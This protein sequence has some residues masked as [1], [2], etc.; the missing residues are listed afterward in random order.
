LKNIQG[1][2]LSAH[3]IDQ[4]DKQLDKVKSQ[5]IIVK[6]NS[7]KVKKKMFVEENWS[8]KQAM[9][10]KEQP[11]VHTILFISKFLCIT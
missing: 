6:E 9:A 1:Q 2:I 3:N 4:H 11:K 8:L 7:N 5:T 10:S